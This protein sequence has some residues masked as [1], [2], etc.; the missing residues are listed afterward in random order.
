MGDR[1]RRPS[2]ARSPRSFVG[3]ADEFFSGD[4]DA[5]VLGGR[6]ARG[7]GGEE[8]EGDCDGE[9]S[10]E[11]DGDGSRLVGLDDFLLRDF[12]N[13]LTM[14][15]SSGR[16][17]PGKGAPFGRWMRNFGTLKAVLFGRPGCCTGSSACCRAVRMLP[18]SFVSVPCLLDFLNSQRQDRRCNGPKNTV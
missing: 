17:A 7:G 5:D 14:V 8:R 3:D 6:E 12:G 18:S 11:D 4:D 15:W 10:E 2:E 9:G 1:R 16:V 13:R